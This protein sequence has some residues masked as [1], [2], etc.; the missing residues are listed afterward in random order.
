MKQYQRMPLLHGMR[1]LRFYVHC[2]AMVSGGG[3]DETMNPLPDSL[4][5]WQ[6]LHLIRC[7]FLPMVTLPWIVFLALIWTFLETL[8]LVTFA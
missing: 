2:P 1:M 4:G 8:F 3:G 6:A 7:A 5:A